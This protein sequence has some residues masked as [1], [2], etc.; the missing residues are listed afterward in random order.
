MS[1]TSLIPS[2]PGPSSPLTNS[3]TYH[4][5]T[6]TAPGPYILGV[7]EAGRGPVLGPLV[8]GVAYCPASWKTD[9]EQLGFAGKHLS[10]AQLHYDRSRIFY[11]TLK[12]LLRK[13]VLNY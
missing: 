8:Y 6:P 12:H 10:S 7:D 2:A 1:R 9:L 5:S 3:Y 13:S 4:S 11:Q